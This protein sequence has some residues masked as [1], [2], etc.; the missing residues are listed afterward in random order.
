MR[1]GQV[2]A[3]AAAAALWSSCCLAE[4]RTN[5]TPAA[6][7]GRPAGL[8]KLYADFL[9]SPEAYRRVHLHVLGLDLGD[10]EWWVLKPDLYIVADSYATADGATG[11]TDWFPV[12]RYK[13]YTREYEDWAEGDPENGKTKFHFA[14]DYKTVLLHRAD[15]TAGI[16]FQVY[17]KDT[18][19]SD[20]LE[21]QF[22]VPVSDFPVAGAGWKT[23][24]KGTYGLDSKVRAGSGLVFRLMVTDNSAPLVSER[25]YDEMTYSIAE[26][27]F[28]TV[29]YEEHVL[30]LTNG[31]EHAWQNGKD[32]A[33][34]QT[35]RHTDVDAAGLDGA[36]VWVIGK[37]D[38]FMH[39]HV[40]KKLFMGP[41]AA[42]KYD[43]YLLNWRL[44]GLC[45]FRGFY[46]D[47]N[48]NSHNAYGS[49]DKYTEEVRRTFALRAELGP[50]K[51]GAYKRTVGYA[52]ST[53]AA[54][55]LQ[56]LRSEGTANNVDAVVMN[57]PLLAFEQDGITEFILEDVVPL[58][59]SGKNDDVLSGVKY[60]DGAPDDQKVPFLQR[61]IIL[62]DWVMKIWSAV[63]FPWHARYMARSP[64]HI[65]LIKAIAG[66]FETLEAEKPIVK[67]STLPVLVMGSYGDRTLKG[68][69]IAERSAWASATRDLIMF[70]HN[71]HDV[72]LS[73]DPADTAAALEA[74]AQW[75]RHVAHGGNATQFEAYVADK[76]GLMAGLG[77]AAAATPAPPG[78][79]VFSSAPSAV[80]RVVVMLAVVFVSLASTQSL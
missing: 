51:G 14:W 5:S 62:S 37:A 13:S 69:D 60:L 68:E 65:G 41:N 30:E 55:L 16:R 76:P 12:G 1:A 57:A 28:K 29:K 72:Y 66:F 58:L 78:G 20:D 39:P 52:H 21:M 19:L 23:F 33:V 36:L 11:S 59:S 54:L 44:N 49:F 10:N 27:P 6:G 17:E 64:V 67:D 74:T 4:A 25:E 9:D 53:G 43:V 46:N 77:G 32:R 79:P 48:F 70:Q 47:A 56:Y 15:G 42:F 75:M 61:G 63:R 18:I 35:W 26:G 7:T 50:V 38:A 34:V 31:E 40:F 3:L 22:D 45:L 2:C 8:P 80:P 24:R 71:G 73:S